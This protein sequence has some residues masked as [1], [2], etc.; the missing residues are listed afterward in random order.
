MSLVWTFL[1]GVAAAILAFF[2]FKKDPAPVQE[3]PK[4][5]ELQDKI[6]SNSE[7]LSKEEEL[8]KSL[9]EK[10]DDEDPTSL[11]DFFNNRK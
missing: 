3:D 2:K 11:P 9:E 6:D 5:K 7:E 4:V 10:K 8:R 1:A